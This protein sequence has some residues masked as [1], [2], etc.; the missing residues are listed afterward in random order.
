MVPALPLEDP[1]AQLAATVEPV[2][3]RGHLWTAF[4]IAVCA[5]GAFAYS[6]QLARGLEVTAMRDYVS[7][8]LY[9]STFVFYIGISHVGALMSAVLRLTGAEWRRPITRM[10]EAITF[11]SLFMAGLMPVIDM[12]RP[13]R[14][15][16]LLLYGRLQSPINW[17]I[18]CLATYF[19][20]STLFLYLP[21]IPDI[22]WLRDNRTDFPWWRRALYRV[23]ALRWQGLPDQKRRLHRSMGILTAVILPVAISVHTVV[24]WIFGMTLRPGWNSTI[25][26]PYFVVGALMSGCAAVIVAMAVFRKVYRLEKWVTPVHFRNLGL[27]L[28]VLTFAYLYFNVAEYWTPAY[29]RATAERQLLDDLFFG[30]YAWAYWTTQVLGIVVPLGILAFSR[31]RGSVRWVVAAAALNVSAAWAKRYLIV[32]LTMMYPFLPI[33]EVRPEW[34][35]YFPTWVEWSV[36]LGSLGGFLLI[37]TIFARLFPIVSMW[38]VQ[39]GLHKGLDKGRNAR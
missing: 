8:G 35:H 16:H 3:I 18:L 23:L 29:K 14:M 1:T 27:L 19:A 34:S 4:L 10:A 2:G 22:A 6:V 24:A 33:Q 12:G 25:F 5:W 39:E 21:L 28:F 38:E 37:Y 26:G 17:D 31:T 32:V 36:T 9:I 7:W 30:D 11:S 20:G 13:D 15:H